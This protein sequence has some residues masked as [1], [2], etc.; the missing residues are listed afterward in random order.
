[1]ISFRFRIGNLAK[2][3][4]KCEASN[5]IEELEMISDSVI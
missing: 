3:K 2:E 4:R 1:M 5:V